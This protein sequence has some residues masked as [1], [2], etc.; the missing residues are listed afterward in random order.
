M[1]NA[2]PLTQPRRAVLR[3]LDLDA[4]ATPR[5]LDRP[6][7]HIGRARASCGLVLTGP[8]VAPHHCCLR[9]DGARWLLRDRG[10]PAGTYVNSRRIHEPTELHDGDRI[11]LGLHLL[12][13]RTAP[14]LEPAHVLARLRDAPVDLRFTLPACAPAGDLP[15]LASTGRRPD[16][17]P[18]PRL[19]ALLRPAGLA[20][21]A[22]LALSFAV[23]VNVAPA[24]DPPTAALPAADPPTA[25]LPT[26]LA[27]PRPDLAG[28]AVH[29]LAAADLSPGTS[30]RFTEPVPSDTQ[31]TARREYLAEPPAFELPTDARARGRPDAGALERALALPPS[32][33]YTIR[34]PA[35]AYGSSATIAELM[36]ALASFRN[37]SGY[38]GELVVGDLS[39]ARGGRYGPHRSH[40]SGRDVDLWLP[41]RGGVYRR[42]CVHCG[43]DLCRPEPRE[44]DWLATW[45]LV[46]ALASRGAVQDIF[47]DWTLQPPLIAAARRFG[48]PEP[49]I[50]RQIQH[51]VRGRASLVKHADGHS[52]HMHVRFR[53]PDAAPDC[54]STP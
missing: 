12:E 52:H 18:G 26:V 41:V 43:T 28:A 11:S 23:A 46:Q 34:C 51:P 17:L 40:Q 20:A 15:V 39:Q 33:D 9:R 44:V 25:A 13:F 10:A 42:G 35:H 49:Q 4:D 2:R 24:A 19:A 7:L 1:T 50:A 6:V 27:S 47:L 48:V 5:L 36:H 22:A 53:C 14:S 32:P 29:D 45:Q 21:V 38:R 37:H 16:D 54:V 8:G 31:L 30:T 3:L